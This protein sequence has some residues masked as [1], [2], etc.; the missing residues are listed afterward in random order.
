MLS[1]RNML[2]ICRQ[3]RYLMKIGK[4]LTDYHR[5]VKALSV[6]ET[7]LNAYP[8]VSDT[9]LKAFLCRHRDLILVIIP[10]NQTNVREALLNL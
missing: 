2:A 7:F 5:T 9:N 10:A 1:Y 3:R 4:S 6:V 8:S